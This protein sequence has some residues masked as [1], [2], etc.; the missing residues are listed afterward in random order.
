[1][2]DAGSL[3]DFLSQFS[4]KVHKSDRKL[5]KIVRDAYPIGVPALIMK[6]GT[7]RIG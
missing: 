2:S 3:D 5:A 1:M 7:D 6:S 4:D